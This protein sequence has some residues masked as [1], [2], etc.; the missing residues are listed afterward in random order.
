MK[1]NYLKTVGFRKFKKEFETEIYDITSITGKNRSG[2]SNILY[3]II[4]IILGT[5]LSGNEKTCLINKKCDSSYGELHF[6]DNM[7]T[8]HTLV[9]I[10]DRYNNN[11]NFIMLDGKNVTQD[12][13]INFYRDK[14]L[15]LSI[16]N[17]MYFLSK[18]TAE[19]KE[20][21]D[22]YLSDIKPKTICA[23]INNILKEEIFSYFFKGYLSQIK[24]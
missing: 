7:G 5:N 13:L 9:R 19:Q 18:K 17:P 12:D 3:A 10:R 23:N 4:N 8:E 20:M 1:I 11:K 21:V 22:K 6:T 14:K 15:F 16:V 24:Y 2:K